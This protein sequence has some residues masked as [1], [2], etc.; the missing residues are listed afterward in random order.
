MSGGKRPMAKFYSPDFIRNSKKI[1]QL[2]KS[3]IKIKMNE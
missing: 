1:L 2:E 3:K